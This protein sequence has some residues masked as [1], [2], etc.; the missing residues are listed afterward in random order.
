MTPKVVELPAGEKTVKVVSGY[1]HS[2]AITASGNLYGWGFNSQQQ[3]SHSA[4]YA[5]PENPQHAIMT[6]VLLNTGELDRKFIVDAAAG[7]EHT[8]VVAQ[9]RREEKCISELVFACGNNLKGQLG[10]NRTCHVTGWTLI[11]DISELF[12]ESEKGLVPLHVHKL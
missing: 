8:V 9:I 6:P 7:E 4:E 12:D 11:D 10:I 2:L 3:L 5:D 1:R